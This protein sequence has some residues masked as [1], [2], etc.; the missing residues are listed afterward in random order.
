MY[1]S[2]C[3]EFDLKVVVGGRCRCFA[4]YAVASRRVALKVITTP[5]KTKAWETILLLGF[6]RVSL[7]G[8]GLL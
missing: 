5:L 8:V 1:Y 6:E 7:Q 2:I 4:F 3:L